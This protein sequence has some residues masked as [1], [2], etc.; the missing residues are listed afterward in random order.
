M[1]ASPAPVVPTAPSEKPEASSKEQKAVQPASR[2]QKYVTP[3]LV[4]L[5][6]LAILLTITRNWNAWEGGKVE[7]VTDDA[8]V[9]GDLTPLSTK[10]AGIVRAVQVSDYQQVHKGD[11]L[12]ELQD[13]DYQAQVDQANAAVAAAKAAIENNFRQRQLQDAKI[14]K[15]LAGIDQAKAQIAAAQAGK[16]AIEAGLVRARSERKRQEGLYQTHSTTQQKLEAVVADEQSLSAQLASR[17]ADLSQARTGLR[18]SE[19]SAE[20]ER[21]G[22]TVLLSQ[23]M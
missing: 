7:Q 19:L 4:L 16:E 22:K 8:Y 1:A 3:V 17:E 18:S 21:I 5:C 11:L 12:V 23:E 6:A 10:V 9:R 14:A 2:W 20:A 15:A 13:N